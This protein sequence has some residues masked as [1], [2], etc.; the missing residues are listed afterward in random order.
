MS[1]V[2][3]EIIALPL[4]DPEH[5]SFREELWIVHAEH[6]CRYYLSILTN[7][8]YYFVHRDVFEI[9]FIEYMTT[10]ASPKF[11]CWQDSSYRYRFALP[12]LQEAFHSET[13]IPRKSKIP[14][15]EQALLL[16]VLNPDWSDEAIVARLKTTSKQLARWSDFQLARQEQNRGDF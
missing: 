15:E 5:V 8:D 4:N 6:G 11:I 7:R 1:E 3:S 9:N 10:H 12:F 16:L 14:R 2:Y 13:T